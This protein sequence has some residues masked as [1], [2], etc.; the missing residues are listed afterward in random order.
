MLM[1]SR[2]IGYKLINYRSLG[3]VEEM[4]A[5]FTQGIPW[6]NGGY[7]A[8]RKAVD[9]PLTNLI[10]LRVKPLLKNPTLCH[11]KDLSYLLTRHLANKKRS[12][13]VR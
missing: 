4:G 11:T 13:M 9:D 8:A 3:S 2:V 7:A 1:E 12:W 6:E 10:S 5:S